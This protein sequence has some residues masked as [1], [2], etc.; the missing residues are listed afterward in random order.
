MLFYPFPAEIKPESLEKSEEDVKICETQKEINL[1]EEISKEAPETEV[2]TEEVEKVP[3]SAVEVEVS[4]AVPSEITTAVPE[5]V[6]KTEVETSE[7]VTENSEKLIIKEEGETS[8]SNE[9]QLCVEK[10]PDP[11]IVEVEVSGEVV[12][13]E[14]AVV[15]VPEVV[16]KTEIDLT[17][18][19]VTEKLIIGEETSNSNADQLDVVENVPEPAVV[20]VE[21]SEEIPPEIAVVVPELAENTE[22]ETI[23]ENVTEKLIDEETSNSNADQLDVVEK[24]PEPVEVSEEVPETKVRDILFDIINKKIYGLAAFYAELPLV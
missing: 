20:E 4:E 18:E 16:E 7:N 21:V 5:L 9:D 8:I 1:D 10:V 13:P 3:E 6:E 19:N 11:A 22:V 14:I 2:V 15:V 24:V 23:S 17:S 12:S